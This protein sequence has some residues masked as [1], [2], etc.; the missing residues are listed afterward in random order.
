MNLDKAKEMVMMKL[1]IPCKFI[2]RGSRN[3][4]E[5]FEGKI[6]NCYS[7][8]FIIRTVDGVTKSFSYNDFIIKNLKIIS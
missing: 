7:S 2:Y 4:L 5:E 1:N 3:Q 6:T 8:V